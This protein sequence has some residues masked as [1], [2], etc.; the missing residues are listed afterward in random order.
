MSHLPQ[1]RTKCLAQWYQPDIIQMAVPSDIISLGIAD[2]TLQPIPDG[3]FPPGTELT[4]KPSRKVSESL[5][6]SPSELEVQ[7]TSPSKCLSCCQAV[8]QI[9]VLDR[10]SLMIPS[11]GKVVFSTRKHSSRNR[12][13]CCRSLVLEAVVWW[14]RWAHPHLNPVSGSVWAVLRNTAVD[15]VIAQWVVLLELHPPG[16]AAQFLFTS[17]GSWLLLLGWAQWTPLRCAGPWQLSSRLWNFKPAHFHPPQFLLE[18]QGLAAQWH[19]SF[20]APLELELQSTGWSHIPT[21]VAW[22]LRN[23][24]AGRCVTTGRRNCKGKQTINGSNHSVSVKSSPKN[25]HRTLEWFTIFSVMQT[26]VILM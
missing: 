6:L 20:W 7:K 25:K 11:P 3:A 4:S 14:W 21:P 24:A 22:T 9:H 2:S 1:S 18:E 23:R 16:K 13:H 5:R 17:T 15:L 26:S 10:S 12:T 19:R 8:K